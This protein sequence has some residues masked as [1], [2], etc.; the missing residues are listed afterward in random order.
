MPKVKSATVLSVFVAG[1]IGVVA[2][3]LFL[4]LYGLVFVFLADREIISWVNILPKVISKAGFWIHSFVLEMAIASIVILTI[5]SV[6]G[7]FLKMDNLLSSAIALLLFL[8]TKIYYI[9]LIHNDIY[10]L[11]SPI[12]YFLSTSVFT[13]MAFWMS[14]SIGGFINKRFR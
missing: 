13:L 1:I 6:V 3:N 4:R 14:F 8:A 10:D 12:A 9:L 11:F 7:T 5:G 2:S